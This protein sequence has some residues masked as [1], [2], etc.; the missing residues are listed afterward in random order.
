M[1]ATV[2]SVYSFGNGGADIVTRF[3]CS[4]ETGSSDR[5]LKSDIASAPASHP[6]SKAFGL[7]VAKCSFGTSE[8]DRQRGV[9]F[10]T[11]VVEK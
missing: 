11:K 2:R 5:I 6:S 10:Y 3:V 7:F 9:Y 4:V 1:S 8:A